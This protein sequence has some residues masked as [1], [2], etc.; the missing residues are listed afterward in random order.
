MASGARLI[1]PIAVS[2]LIAGEEL[3]A[4]RVVIWHATEAKTVSYPAGAA[5]LQI[6]GV[7]M[8]AADSGACVDVCR[9]GDCLL[10][11]NGTTDIAAGDL[12]E[13]EGTDGMGVK[14]ATT[15]GT[16]YRELIGKAN[17]AGTEDGHEISVFVSM[18]AWGWTS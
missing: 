2:T 5:D 15:D 7:T 8:A 9:L 17:E 10:T 16:T 11:V 12:I 14:R 3:A 4:H 13:I 6:A 18:A 1:N